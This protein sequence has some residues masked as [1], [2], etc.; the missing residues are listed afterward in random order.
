M[1][2]PTFSRDDSHDWDDGWSRVPHGLWTIDAPAGAKVLLGWL[3]S[4]SP[5]F[6]PKVTMT[7]ARKAVGS[8]STGAWM[9]RLS[10]LGYIQVHEAPNGKRASI[11]LKM[12]PWRALVGRRDQ[13]EI[14]SVTSPKSDRIEEQGEDHASSLR[15]EDNPESVRAATTESLG[16]RA[17]KLTKEYFDW[18][19]AEHPG[20]EP[21]I[22]FPA[23]MGNA[24]KLLEVGHQPDDIVDAMKTARGWTRKQ[25]ADEI[26]R[27]RALAEERPTTAAIPHALVR[28]FAKAEPF[29]QR[30][31]VGFTPK[32]KAHTMRYCAGLVAQGYGVGETMIRLA[33][34]L[35]QGAMDL[36]R[37]WALNNVDCPR[38]EGE[39]DDYADAMERAWVNR[40]W[41]V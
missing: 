13:S 21:T 35:R 25:L 12:A 1:T 8:S 2:T 28:A 3:H 7:H 29:F 11:T 22:G 27:K 20:L 26:T 16:S 39:L 30:H 34:A 41:N 17:Q 4:H 19:K 9:V 38:F 24:K 31:S 5:A 40:R 37:P 36:D 14:G 15:S 33:L 23:L 6:L 10:Q 32:A 18:Y